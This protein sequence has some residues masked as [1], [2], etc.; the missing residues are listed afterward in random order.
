EDLPPVLDS[1]AA[2]RPGAPLVHSEWA[3]YAAPDALVRQSNVCSRATLIQGDVD[4]AFRDAARIFEQ[5]F[6]T[7]SVHQTPME[8]RADLADGDAQGR[9]T[10]HASTQHPFGVRAQIAEAL[11][12]PLTDVRVIAPHVGGGFGS[13]LEASVEL[14]ATLLA[15]KAR[16][17]VKLVN[18]RDDDLS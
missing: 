14:Y 17:P 2:L 11:G 7:H 1:L 16:R 10:L 13:K 12:L 4:A 18:S 3:R 6:T 5:T 9:V 15:R 8:T